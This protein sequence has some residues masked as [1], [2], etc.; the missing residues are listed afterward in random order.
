MVE[1]PTL[2][3]LH[4]GPGFDHSTLANIFE[5]LAADLQLV[6]IDHRGQGRSDDADVS[7]WNLEH[8]VPDIPDLCEVLEL[9]RPLI[10]GQ[11]F[12]GVVALAVAARYPDLP[13]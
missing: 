2:L 12:G 8:W 10:L 7:H 9:E 3:L 6:L 13:A 1:R 4:G 11:S 5:P